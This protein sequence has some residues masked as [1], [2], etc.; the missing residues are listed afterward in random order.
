M[1]KVRVNKTRCIGESRP[2]FVI[3]EIGSNHNRSL[4]MAKELI[5]AAAQ[6]GADAV[7]FQLFEGEK[8]YS[9][10]TP[11]FKLYDKNIV[12]LLDEI[13]LPREWAPELKEYSEKKDIIFFSSVTH[14]QDVD[15]LEDLGVGLYKLASFELVDLDLI[16]YTAKTQKP[17]ILSTGMAD[18]K[19]VED[20]Y[21]AC[22]GA[23]NKKV[24]LLQCASAYPAP[25][26]SMNL[27]AINTLKDR[28]KTITGLSD[29]TM[30]VHVTLGAVALG[31]KVIERHFTLSRKLKGPDHPFAIEPDELGQ[32]MLQIRQ[33]ES[34]L[35]SG[36]KKGPSHGEL[37]FYDKARRSLHAAIDIP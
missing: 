9:R 16:E 5:D 11:K 23:G 32:M 14:A 27:K 15:L 2:C 4:S 10:K 19:E 13:S 28:F 36:K 22:L 3:A 6:A 8:H 37:E 18:L 24:I 31:A 20:A 17:L 33:L 35:G 30:G 26:E 29:H 7:K 12:D 25:Y 1:M 34:A 21:K